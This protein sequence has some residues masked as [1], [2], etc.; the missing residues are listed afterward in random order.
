MSWSP[1]L[2]SKYTLLVI[3]GPRAASTDCAQKTAASVTTTKMSDALAKNILGEKKVK[4][5]D[6]RAVPLNSTCPGKAEE[7]QALP[8]NQIETFSRISDCTLICPVTLLAAK[9]Y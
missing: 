1:C 2:M 6:G 3:F 7:T 9:Q 4:C 8:S 5:N